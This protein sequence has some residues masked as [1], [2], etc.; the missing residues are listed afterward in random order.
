MNKL[1]FE[2][3][4]IFE[5]DWSFA[6]SAINSPFSSA[7]SFPLINSGLPFFL[8]I[9]ELILTLNL[10]GNSISL[11]PSIFWSAGHTSWINVVAAETGFPGNPK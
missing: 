4:L 11:I 3:E 7:K 10:R 1:E 8:L 2:I 9:S 6:I 5:D